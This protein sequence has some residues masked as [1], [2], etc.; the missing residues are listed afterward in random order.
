MGP[1]Y[2]KVAWQGDEPEYAMP[3]EVSV[4][5]SLDRLFRSTPGMDPCCVLV[6][7]LLEWYLWSSH[8][9]LLACV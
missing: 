1:Q 7:S 9:C 4:W 8:V 6:G 2:A 3:G 5:T